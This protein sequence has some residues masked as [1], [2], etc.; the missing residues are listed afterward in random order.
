MPPPP[1]YI[2]IHTH[3]RTS[4]SSSEFAYIRIVGLEYE[5]KIMNGSN[6]ISVRPVVDYYKYI[7]FYGALV[8]SFYGPSVRRELMARR[9][10]W[11][12]LQGQSYLWG[13]STS[14]QIKF[15]EKRSGYLLVT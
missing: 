3:T 2:Y 11:E 4:E 1:I 9:L 12:V 14:L 10:S 8:S 15:L 6:R 7:P 5:N 13:A